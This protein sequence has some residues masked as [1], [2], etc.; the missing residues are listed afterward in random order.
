MKM[1]LK[2]PKTLLCATGTGMPHW[3]IYCNRP[4]VFRQTDLPPAF[5]PEMSRMRCFC[6]RVISNGTT[7]RGSSSRCSILY[8]SNF[9]CKS[10]CTAMAQ[11][12]TC[13]SSI[14]GSV[15]FVMMAHFALARMKSICAR[16]S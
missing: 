1:L 9:S 16:N 14:L 8:V 11:S 13:L 6:V 5:G 2:M 4:T 7:L 10:G 3:N 15:L 12:S